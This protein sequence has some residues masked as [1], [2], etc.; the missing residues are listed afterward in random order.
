MRPAGWVIVAAL[1]AI[2]PGGARAQQPDPAGPVASGDVQAFLERWAA[3]TRGLRSLRVEFTQ[4]KKLKLL[5]KPLVSHGVTLLRGPRVRMDVRDAEGELELILQVVPGQEGKPDEVRLFHP[6]LKRQEVYTLQAGAPPPESPFL[7]FGDDVRQL[8]RRYEV[9]LERG[10]DERQAL[11]L[12]PRGESQVASMRLEFQGAKLTAVEQT[13]RRGGAVRMEITRW[14]ANPA[15]EE[16]ALELAL[17]PG[18]EV[19]REDLPR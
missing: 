17:P 12:R 11:V 16:G 15:L 13:D 5:R 14:E 4:T 6:R 19:V 2:A 7:I 8:P 1:A 10:D 18:T 9:A 3:E